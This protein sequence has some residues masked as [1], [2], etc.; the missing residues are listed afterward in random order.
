MNF[1]IKFIYYLTYLERICCYVFPRAVTHAQ[2]L[3][4]QPSIMVGIQPSWLGAVWEQPCNHGCCLPPAWEDH[5]NYPQTLRISLQ[6]GIE[7]FKGD[8]QWG[9]NYAERREP[10]E[11]PISKIAVRSRGNK[12]P[13]EYGEVTLINTKSEKT[14]AKTAN[15]AVKLV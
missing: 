6:Y 9:P 11:R 10:F 12:R 14:G 13:Y 15:W 5:Q 8:L 4:L 3:W 1:W 2:W 7:G